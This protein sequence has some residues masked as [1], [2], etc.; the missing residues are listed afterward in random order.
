MCCSM[1]ILDCYDGRADKLSSWYGGWCDWHLRNSHH[2][3][4][5][6]IDGTDWMNCNRQEDKKTEEW[7]SS[8]GPV[9][10]RLLS[11][12]TGWLPG[13][14]ERRWMYLQLEIIVLWALRCNA[15]RDEWTSFCSVVVQYVEMKAI[16]VLARGWHHH[17]V[18]YWFYHASKRAKSVMRTNGGT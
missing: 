6:L 4:M 10:Q 1:R 14:I 17:M 16:R 5:M 8:E 7:F 13:W 3:S 9:H 11:F 12:G 15:H 2:T 18:W